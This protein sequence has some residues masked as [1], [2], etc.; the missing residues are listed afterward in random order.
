MCEPII[1]NGNGPFD[2]KRTQMMIGFAWFEDPHSPVKISMWDEE[3]KRKM[4]QPVL[5]NGYHQLNEESLRMLVAL[6]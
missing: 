3:T 1:Q 6:V 2:S 4:R 5:I